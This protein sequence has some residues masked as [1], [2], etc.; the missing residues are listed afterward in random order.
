MTSAR[1]LHE[2]RQESNEEDQENRDYTV[3]DPIEHGDQVVAAGLAAKNVALGVDPADSRLLVE[4]TNVEHCKN[5]SDLEG[6]KEDFEA[7]YG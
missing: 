2:Q 1:T 6:G 4:G 3:F 7:T 5:V